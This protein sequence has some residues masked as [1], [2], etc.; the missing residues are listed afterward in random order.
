MQ[1]RLGK[2]A[3][4]LEELLG[5]G[6]WSNPLGIHVTFD[7]QLEAI[8]CL[9]PKAYSKRPELPSLLERVRAELATRKGVRNSVKN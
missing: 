6:P 5:V 7:G 4:S 8:L 3:P 1:L 2:E 9:Y